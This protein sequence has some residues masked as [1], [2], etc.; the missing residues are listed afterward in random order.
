VIVEEGYTAQVWP[1]LSAA[2]RAGAWAGH[3]K[4]EQAGKTGI[5]VPGGRVGLSNQSTYQE[6]LRYPG[7]QVNDTPSSLPRGTRPEFQTTL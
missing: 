7:I 5:G 6:L 2:R 4:H 3:D 1:P